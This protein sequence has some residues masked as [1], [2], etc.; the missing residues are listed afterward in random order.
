MTAKSLMYEKSMFQ[1]SLQTF[2]LL[3]PQVH[4]NMQFFTISAPP[5]L[6]CLLVLCFVF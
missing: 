2:T 6:A 4:S 5:C 3:S 1:V